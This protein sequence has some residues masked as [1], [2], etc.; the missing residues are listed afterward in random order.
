LEPVY[1]EPPVKEIWEVLKGE[2]ASKVKSAKELGTVISSIIAIKEGTPGV[3]VPLRGLEAMFRIYPDSEATLFRPRRGGGNLVQRI[4]NAATEFRA[5]KEC[6]RLLKPDPQ[7]ESEVVCER[8]IPRSLAACLLANMFMCSLV[9]PC[10]KDFNEVTM[11][12]LLTAEPHLGQEIAKLR[13]FVN[14]F[15]RVFCLDEQPLRGEI[16]ITRMQSKMDTD[17]W[18]K[19]CAPVAKIRAVGLGIGF[20][21][22]LAQ[23]AEWVA[24]DPSIAEQSGGDLC[25]E[26]D[27]ANMYIG[28][29]VLSGGCVQEEI[30]FAIAPENCL[31]CLLCPVMRDEE[32]VQ[33]VGAQQFSEY[34][35]YGFY[36]Q[37]GGDHKSD[38]RADTDGTTLVAI[39]AID[40]IRGRGSKQWGLEQQLEE[41]KM[42]RELNKAYAGFH[43]ADPRFGII[44]TGNWGCG[45]FGGD[46][47]LKA[48]LQLIA[49]SARKRPVLYFPFD[50]RGLGRSLE[51]FSAWCADEGVTAGGLWE[52]LR[53]VAKSLRAGCIPGD[54]DRG[55]LD[56]LKK[57][58]A[59][60][61]PVSAVGP[62]AKRTVEER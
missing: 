41:H 34:K 36:L 60:S 49:A 1:L 20:E 3:K 58:L 59:G 9:P 13:M 46:H 31:S 7:C 51:D 44:A 38:L 8:R 52:G 29:G 62:P 22:S 5:R 40:A 14:Y 18:V 11:L 48:V 42:L 16:R 12:S 30:R 19:A 57:V 4:M 23:A 50:V 54:M 55:L 25:L 10:D 24:Q 61:A 56:I 2:E 35:G 45:V 39:T 17:S 28:G 27:F 21:D 43:P 33:I 32:A 15:E 26:A 47:Q 53:S 37:Y 6:L